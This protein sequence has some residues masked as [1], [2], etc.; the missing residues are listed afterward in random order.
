MDKIASSVMTALCFAS[1]V[2]AW[3][4]THALDGSVYFSDPQVTA[5]AI[6]P[7]GPPPG[8]T[9]ATRP[10]AHLT[11]SLCFPPDFCQQQGADQG[12]DDPAPL[13]L[14]TS[15]NYLNSC[16][17]TQ[18]QEPGLTG[19]AAHVEEFSHGVQRDTM[20]ADAVYS[21]PSFDVAPNTLATFTIRLH[22]ALSAARDAFPDIGE[23]LGETQFVPSDPVQWQPTYFSLQLSTVPQSFDRLIVATLR[24]DTADVENVWWYLHSRL[25]LQLLPAVPEPAH[26]LMLLAGLSLMLPKAGL[27]PKSVS[28]QQKM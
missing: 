20:S 6:D 5:V 4:Q 27:I 18:A 12:P 26:W 10:F 24:N 14:H 17:T 15:L 23:L 21:V 22:G 8:V 1:A 3:A 28:P 25:D 9:Q 13:A 19:L 16:T 7:N 2:P 11:S